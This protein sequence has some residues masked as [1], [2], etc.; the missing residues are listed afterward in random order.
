MA[1]NELDGKALYTIGGG[2]PHG[3]VPIGNGAVR[4][5]D[6]I[7][8][9]K[10]SNIRPSNTPSVRSVLRENAMLRRQLHVQSRQIR[11]T[12]QIAHMFLLIISL[13]Q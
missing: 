1:Y 5:A 6:V 12:N 9:A 11:V 13:V 4:K 10:A 3:R 7:S 8:A 2:L